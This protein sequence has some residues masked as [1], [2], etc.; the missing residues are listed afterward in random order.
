MGNPQIVVLIR[1]AL[2]IGV[3]LVLLQI[4]RLIKRMIEMK[5]RRE[6]ISSV[7]PLDRG[8]ESERDLVYKLIRSGIP[9]KTI[10][11]D[12][13]IEKGNSEYSQIDVVVPTKVGILV[14]E[15]K[16]YS[17]WIFGNG[18]HEQWTQVMTYGKEKYRFYNPIR[19]NA[20]HIRYL[21]KELN[22]SDNTPVFSII[23][24]YG[25]CALRELNYIPRNTFVI[26]PHRLSDVIANIL[27][28]Y[29]EAIFADK[30]EIVRLLRAAVDRGS[31]TIATQQH[32]QNISDKLGKHRI[33]E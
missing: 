15:I 11:H 13:L 17:G 19:Q 20:S 30:W 26:K 25:N 12:L 3:F 8:T 28:N 27:N 23:V 32:I 31:S 29:P 24:F 7:T 16:D 21:R 6:L 5:H 2:I 9:A 33:Y 18:G 22:L 14:F 4:V 1:I 10:F